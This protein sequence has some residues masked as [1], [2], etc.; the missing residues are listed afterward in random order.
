[1]S[2]PLPD[3]GY[4]VDGYKPRKSGPEY[5][6]GYP[7]YASGKPGGSDWQTPEGDAGGGGSVAPAPR[8]PKSPKGSGGSY[9]TAT[10]GV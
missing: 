1:M 8:K 3:P 10:V 9:A 4:I 7:P 5:F 6:V 2:D